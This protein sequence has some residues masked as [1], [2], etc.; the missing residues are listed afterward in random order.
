MENVDNILYQLFSGDYDITPKWGEK[1]QKLRNQIFAEMDKVAA[2]C[3]EEFL[4]H[5]LDLDGEWNEWKN[6]QYYRSGFFLGARLMLEA[7]G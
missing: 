1:Q 4:E 3:G 2:A 6:F 7:L 5:L